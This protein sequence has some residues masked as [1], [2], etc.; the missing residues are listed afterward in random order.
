MFLS[1]SIWQEYP[2][3]GRS[4]G[5]YIILYQVGTIDHV[6]HVPGLVDHSGGKSE[7][8]ASCTTGMALAYFMMLIHELLKKNPDIVP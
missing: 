5:E 6:T 2:D 3:T 8:N 7:Y 1:D 4:T